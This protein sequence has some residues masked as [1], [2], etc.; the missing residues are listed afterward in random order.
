MCTSIFASVFLAF[1]RHFNGQNMYNFKRHVL[2]MRANNASIN[3]FANETV[4]R[5]DDSICVMEI[6]VLNNTV[7]ALRSSDII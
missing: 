1:N 5:T 4:Q 6:S 3:S 7:L 2:S